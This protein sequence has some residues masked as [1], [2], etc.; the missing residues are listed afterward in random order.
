MQNEDEAIYAI[1]R[2]I[3]LPIVHGSR[4]K[5]PYRSNLI[6][7]TKDPKWDGH[8]LWIYSESHWGDV[9]HEIAHWLEAPKSCRR[10]PNWGLDNPTKD[11]D[12][13]L[14]IKERE[15]RTD[16]IQT[17]LELAVEAMCSENI[18]VAKRL[19]R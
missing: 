11:A 14:E 5:P 18:L 4:P 1:A 7:H 6:P 2:H 8:I 17:G 16:L 9:A 12:L 19:T 3:G 10:L 15:D 13:E